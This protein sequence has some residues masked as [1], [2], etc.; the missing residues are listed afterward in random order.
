VHRGAA[1]ITSHGNLHNYAEPKPFSWA[2][3]RFSSTD[4]TLQN[5]ALSPAGDALTTDITPWHL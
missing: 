2:Y 1:P 4:F 5:H 3:A